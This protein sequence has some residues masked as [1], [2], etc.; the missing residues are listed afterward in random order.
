MTKLQNN[1]DCL[2]CLLLLN[3][4]IIASSEVFSLQTT[5]GNYYYNKQEIVTKVIAIRNVYSK[6]KTMYLF[7]TLL[8]AYKVP[9]SFPKVI[10]GIT[11]SL[12][13]SSSDHFVN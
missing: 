4:I 7:N 11:A 5:I 6:V 3:I 8:R 9:I 12:T 2:E 10:I 1:N 13:T